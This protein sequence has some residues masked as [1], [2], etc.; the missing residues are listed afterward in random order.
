MIRP[1]EQAHLSI[2]A[3][4]VR[5]AQVVSAGDFFGRIINACA[6]SGASG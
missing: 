1:V 2:A 6:T 4:G 5:S 3:R